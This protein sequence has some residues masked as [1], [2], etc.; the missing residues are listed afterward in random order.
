MDDDTL[1]YRF[2]ILLLMGIVII[3][4]GFMLYQSKVLSTLTYNWGLVTI[5]ELERAHKLTKLERALGYTGFIHHYKNYLLRRSDVYFE[6]AIS[7]FKIAN[8]NLTKLEKDSL[9]DDE[10]KNILIISKTIN[11]YYQNLQYAHKYWQDIPTDELDKRVKVDDLPA[12]KALNELRNLIEQRFTTQYKS[13][14]LKNQTLEKNTLISTIIVTTVLFILSIVFYII[15]KRLSKTYRENN[16]ILEHSPD[17][18]ISTDEHGNIL[19]ANQVARNLFE[20]T[21]SEFRRLTIEDLIPNKHR[22]GH[23]NKRKDFM[24]KEQHREMAQR[25]DNIQGKTKSG[26][27]VDLNI[28]IASIVVEG[29]KRAIAIVRDI[30]NI[31]YL[32]KEASIDYLTN[33]YN[34]RSIDK[35]LNEEIGRTKRYKHPLTLMLIDIDNFKHLNDKNGHLFGD[36][37]IKAVTEYLKSS[38]RPSDKLGRWGGDEFLLICPE[39]T[40][41]NSITFAERI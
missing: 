39:I 33:S 12:E 18:I 25:V 23:I 29:E 27:Y 26:T 34:R 3:M 4:S 16:I 7:S 31:N 35:Y 40:G 20:Y 9:S 22:R 5:N 21:K 14:H 30:T 24:Q 37:A 36:E 32:K 38:I 15:L 41:E 1:K 11:Q 13:T 10:R 28:E 8:E 19:H 2:I 17:G 6:R